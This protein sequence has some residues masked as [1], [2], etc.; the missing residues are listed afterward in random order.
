MLLLPIV[1]SLPAQEVVL[2]TTSLGQGPYSSMHTLLEKTIFKVDVLTLDLRF[3]PEITARLAAQA[4]GR[5]YSSALADSLAAIALGARDVWARIRFKRGVSLDQ[6]LGGI[7]QNMRRALRAGIIGQEAHDTIT[8]GLPRWY[9][10]LA[11][12][13]ISKGDE[14]F[15]RIRGDTL[16]TIYRAASGEVL[17]DQVDVGPERRLS[18]MGGY[19]A[20]KSDFRKGLIRSL[21]PQ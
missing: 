1:S 6:F 4:E 15:Y 14:M 12:D 17:L 2:D 20:P 16:R 19:Y 18:V 5:R 10:F 21:L 11:E 13:G 7:Y 8:A 3:G 9:G